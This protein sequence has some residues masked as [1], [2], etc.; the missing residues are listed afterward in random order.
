MPTKSFSITLFVIFLFSAIFHEISHGFVAYLF[1][2]RTAKLAGRLSLNPFKH[3]DPLGSVIIP[4]LLKLSGA[5]FTIGYAKPV[6]IDPRHFFMPRFGIICVSLAGPLSNIF[7]AGV[8]VALI[9][10]D[11]F[12][13]DRQHMQL[14]LGGLAINCTLFMFNMLP[15]LPL[16]GGRIV[17]ALLPA[18][19]AKVVS[20]IEPFGIIVVMG[21]CILGPYLEETSGIPIDFM[22]RAFSPMCERL[23]MFLIRLAV[24]I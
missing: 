21:I 14:L 15:V 2:D 6:P 8:F 1:G 13:I 16:D 19:I 11:L 24:P 9:S 18:K 5:N 7:L 23:Y 4:V 12:C 3:L 22:K 10:F 17:A 20:K